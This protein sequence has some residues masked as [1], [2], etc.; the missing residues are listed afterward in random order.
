MYTR[1][2]VVL[3]LLRIVKFCKPALAGAT[4]AKLV[5]KTTA[6][7]TLRLRKE[8]RETMTWRELFDWVD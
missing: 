3:V 4:N 1:S 2:I 5:G 8:V 6:A 7:A